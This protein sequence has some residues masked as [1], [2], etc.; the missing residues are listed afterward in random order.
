MFGLICLNNPCWIA[1]SRC[2][3]RDWF[4]DHSVRS[5]TS[6]IT[7]LESPEHLRPGADD[8]AATEAGGR[9]RARY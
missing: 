4:N 1:D 2:A 8:N 7:H 3:S 9:L 5:N 6:A